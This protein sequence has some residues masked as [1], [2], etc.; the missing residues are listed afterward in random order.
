MQMQ[1]IQKQ[2]PFEHKQGIKKGVAVVEWS[3]KQFGSTIMLTSKLD[4]PFQKSALITNRMFR[5][6]EMGEDEFDKQKYFWDQ[7]QAAQ[8]DLISRLEFIWQAANGDLDDKQPEDISKWVNLLQ[9]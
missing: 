4:V 7:M 5:L 3:Y 6:N 8:Q 1:P 2:L 9:S